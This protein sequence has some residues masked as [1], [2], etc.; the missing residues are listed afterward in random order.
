MSPPLPRASLRLLATTDVHMH[1]SGW[2]PLT[3]LDTPDRGMDRLATRI[4]AEQASATGATV[5]LEN[6]DGLQ[7]TPLGDTC[8]DL[9]AAHPWP[10]ILNALEYDAVGL[11]NHD[12]DFGVPALEA[13]LSRIA[14][15]V[16]CTNIRPDLLR[17]V[18]P[19][20]VIEK[21]V[22]CSDGNLR[23]LKIGLT[24]ALPP[25]TGV[26]NRRWFDTSDVFVPGVES[27]RASVSHL[28]QTGADV[29]FVLCHSGLID[30]PDK[31]GENFAADL[32]ASIDGI[33]GMVL[34]HT[35]LKFPGAAHTGF[36]GTNMDRG[37]VHDVPCVMPAHAGREVGVIDLDLELGAEGW[38]VHD[39]DVRRIGISPTDPVAPDIDAIVSPHVQ[40]TRDALGSRIGTAHA[41]LNT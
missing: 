41:D 6:G 21:A 22:E 37:T 9:G 1:L 16:L 30:G 5:L 7:G 2:D 39:H 14:C 36:E 32:A 31:S 10:D 4:R 26:W 8:A 12:F 17:Y 3:D 34:G 13:V 38:R 11:G 40:A 28:L 23:T 24:A 29:V 27:V 20:K 35:H 33:D 19:H 25:Q 18:H 15:P